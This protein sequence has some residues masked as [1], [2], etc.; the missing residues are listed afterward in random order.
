MH[1]SKPEFI[2]NDPNRLVKM[3]R[4]YILDAL[5]DHKEVEPLVYE[6]WWMV[7]DGEPVL[8]DYGVLMELDA[9]CENFNDGFG[10]CW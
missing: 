5:F 4:Q 10:I 1:F 7:E 2:C 6:L 3:M 8:V 9:T